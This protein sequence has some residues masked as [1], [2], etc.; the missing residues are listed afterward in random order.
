MAYTHATID[1]RPAAR[2]AALADLASTPSFGL[3]MTVP[4][5]AAACSLG[6][7]DPQHLGGNADVAAIEEAVT[8]SLPPEGA[9]LVTVRADADSVGSMAVLAM[10]ADGVSITEEAMERALTIAAADKGH[11]EWSPAA[12]FIPATVFDALKV[13]VMNFRRP[14]EVRVA[15]TRTWLETGDFPGSA[16]ATATV[17]RER[18]ETVDLVEEVQ[19][20]PS[21]RVAVITTGSRFGVSAAYARADVVVV[22]NPKFRFGGGE[23]HRK[24]TVCQ[25]KPGLVDLKAVFAALN[26]TEPGW[27]GSPTIGGS[28]QGVSSVIA[29]DE[30]VEIVEQHL[31]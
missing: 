28:P 29:T 23:P 24:V 11:S 12:G 5:L 2:E 3:E 16:E 17:D 8:C 7:L 15:L 22:V 14:I 19:T 21:G 1:P 18:R 31:L 30:I 25:A 9:R 26:E 4:D 10:R 27:G 6:N 20:S 13:E